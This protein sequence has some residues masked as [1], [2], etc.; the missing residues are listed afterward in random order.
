MNPHFEW[1]VTE[2]RNLNRHVIDRCNLT[3]LSAPGYTHFPQFLA[4][5]QVEVVASL[6]CYLE[7]NCDSQRG[8]GVFRKSIEALKLLNTLGYGKDGRFIDVVAGLQSDRALIASE[9]AEAG[10]ELSGSIAA[11]IRH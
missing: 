6:P 2:V 3:I 7:E 1:F 11:T 10:A 8:N 4:D 9:S 5:H